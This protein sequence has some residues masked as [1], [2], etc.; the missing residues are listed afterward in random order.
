M[1][2]VG[3]LGHS[4][5]IPGERIEA[6]QAEVDRLKTVG[7]DLVCRLVDAEAEVE[8]LR[9]ALEMICALHSLHDT[10]ADRAEHMQTIARQALAQIKEKL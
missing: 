7:V 6:L 9:E 8:L 4:Q 10:K 5:D 3:R 1:K 2:G